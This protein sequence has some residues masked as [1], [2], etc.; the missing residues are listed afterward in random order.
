[1]LAARIFQSNA[2]HSLLDLPLGIG[3]PKSSK[4]LGMEQGDEIFWT[5]EHQFGLPS[6][7]SGADMFTRMIANRV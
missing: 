2:L 5:Q 6:N 1:M 4:S 7:M 3:T